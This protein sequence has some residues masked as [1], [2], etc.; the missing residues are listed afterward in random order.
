V[1]NKHTVTVCAFS[2]FLL[3]F[4]YLTWSYLIQ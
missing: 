1:I 2:T 3:H 4:C